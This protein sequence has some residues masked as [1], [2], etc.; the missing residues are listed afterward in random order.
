MTPPKHEDQETRSNV[1]FF[2]PVSPKTLF[3]SGTSAAKRVFI[4][5]PFAQRIHSRQPESLN[6][7]E[8][9]KTK[10]KKHRHKAEVDLNI[11][12]TSESAR[13]DAANHVRP[14]QEA[15]CPKQE[16]MLIFKIKPTTL[17]L[18]NLQISIFLYYLDFYLNQY[19]N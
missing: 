16:A 19:F 18:R 9:E 8:K 3:K 4:I 17:R 15:V 11:A 5:L 12:L 13:S 6:I 14:K 7:K 10:T 1:F 2:G